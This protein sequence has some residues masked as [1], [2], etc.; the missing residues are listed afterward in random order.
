MQTLPQNIFY[1][2]IYWCILDGADCN[3]QF[4][5]LHFQEDPADSYYTT[6]NACTEE[7]MVFIMDCKVNAS[8]TLLITNFE[9]RSNA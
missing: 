5:K 8:P 4:I 9:Y 6:R 7:P 3:H 1:N 2:S